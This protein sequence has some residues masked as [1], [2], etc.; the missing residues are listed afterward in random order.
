MNNQLNNFEVKL[1]EQRKHIHKC[2]DS[3]DMKETKTEESKHDVK[4]KE[5]KVDSKDDKS[6]SKNF[7]ATAEASSENF[8][9]K[10]KQTYKPEHETLRQ[11]NFGNTL[12][13]AKIANIVQKIPINYKLTLNI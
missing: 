9:P 7:E 6:S 8:Y 13:E 1:P 3:E 11:N 2:Q 10:V 4:D 12:M 5:R